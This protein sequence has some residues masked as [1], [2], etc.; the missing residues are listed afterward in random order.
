MTVYY[1]DGYNLSAEDQEGPGTAG[2]CGLSPGY[3][4]CDVK[5]FIS[6]DMTGQVA[7]ND[8]FTFYVNVLNVFNR[9]APLDPVTYGAYMYN[10][11]QSE[12]GILGRSFRAGVRAKF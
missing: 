10:P 7:V 6:V 9:Q 4:G 8:N 12:A 11:V 2:D 1:T 3:T 5:S